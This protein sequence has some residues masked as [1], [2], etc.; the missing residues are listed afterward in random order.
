MWDA[1]SRNPGEAGDPRLRARPA[2]LAGRG[3]TDGAQ[4][5]AGGA[6]TGRL[7]L[8]VMRAMRRD[9]SNLPRNGSPAPLVWG[10]PVGC[11]HSHSGGRSEESDR[12]RGACGH[13]RAREQCAECAHVRTGALR[14][15]WP[16]PLFPASHLLGDCGHRRRTLVPQ[17]SFMQLALV[18]RSPTLGGLQHCPC[19]VSAG[20]LPPCPHPCPVQLS[21]GQGRAEKGLRPVENGK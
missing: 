14:P 18:V 13:V 10:L 12:T 16:V 6:R 5:E 4:P 7:A 3:G 15:A 19:S 20:Y 11:T 9:V 21:G 2:V 8:S 1:H 17:E